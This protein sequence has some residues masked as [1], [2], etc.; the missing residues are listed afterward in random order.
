MGETPIKFGRGAS[1]VRLDGHRDWLS[2]VVP[3]I[4]ISSLVLLMPTG[5]GSL[6]FQ[7]EVSP[8]LSWNGQVLNPG[9]YVHKAGKP[10]CWGGSSL[11]S[12]F[13]CNPPHLPM[14]DGTLT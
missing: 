5:A 9:P 8:A 1:D 4:G 2:N 13:T 11:L 6:D 12:C 7:A 3:P 14:C 10:L